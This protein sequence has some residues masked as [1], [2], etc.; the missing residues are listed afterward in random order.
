[1]SGARRLVLLRHGRTAWNHALRVQGHLDVE[2]D[3]TGLAQA[4]AAAPRVAAL[5]PRLLWTSDLARARQTAAAVEA[6]TGLTAVPDA[7]LREFG[8]GER[9]GLTHEEYRGLA[10]EEFARFRQ[11]HYD[12]VPGAEPTAAVRTRMAEALGDLLAALGPGETGVAVTHGGA[13]RLAVGELLGWPAEQFRTLR[14]LGNCGWVELVEH[15]E[16]GGLRLEAYNR[17]A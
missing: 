1:M 16:A 6:A 5:E 15:P 14:G 2:L 3:E 11:G 13:A 17:T 12:D 9:E 4:A 10:P 7:R 8:L